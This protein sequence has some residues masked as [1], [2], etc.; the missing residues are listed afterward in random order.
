[1]IKGHYNKYTRPEK[2]LT[3]KFEPT[4]TE[5]TGYIPANIKIRQMM[6]AGLRANPLVQ[7]QFEYNDKLDE[8][9][10][11][12]VISVARKRGCDI[13]DVRREAREIAERQKERQKKL[14]EERQKH[15]EEKKD[16]KEVPDPKPEPESGSQGKEKAVKKEGK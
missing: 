7:K 10:M 16:E 1:M 3:K 13:V 4:K 9:S 12:P 15:A 11:N 8:N 5:Q 2:K 6:Q 14:E